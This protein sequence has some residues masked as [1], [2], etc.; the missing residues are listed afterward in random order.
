MHKYSNHVQTMF[1]P[2]SNCVQT[3]SITVLLPLLT[4]V[5]TC[6][7]SRST[8]A[9]PCPCTAAQLR[10]P[11]N[12]TPQPFQVPAPLLLRALASALPAQL[13]L[14]ALEFFLVYWA[15]SSHS[16]RSHSGVFPVHAVVALSTLF[17]AAGYI[18]YMLVHSAYNGI[19][20]KSIDPVCI[21]TVHLVL[22]VYSILLV[23]Q[24]YSS[25]HTLH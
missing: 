13:L 17:S 6:T 19:L 2:C 12:C 4:D 8:L 5:W 14:C 18:V 21:Y 23:A 24:L 7:K 1:K 11:P 16:P 15:K 20:L 22:Y 9:Y 25:P 10:R 3:V